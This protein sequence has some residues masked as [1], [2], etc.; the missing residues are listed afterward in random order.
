MSQKLFFGVDVGGTFTKV[1]LVNEHGRI[2]SKSKFSSSGFSNKTFFANTLKENLSLML[3]NL[4]LSFKQVK[5][6]GI[7]LPGPVDFD[8][9]IVLSLTNIRGWNKFPLK[10][11]LSKYFKFSVFIEN[12]ANCMALAEDRVGAAKGS[13]YAICLTLGT[14]VGGGIILD[15]Q[16]YRGPYYLGGEIGHV[17]ISSIGPKCQCGGSGCLEKYIGNKKLLNGARSIFNKPISLEE[18]SVLA[19]S[20]DRRAIEFW[21]N[22][23]SI[24]GRA[25]AGIVN[26]LGLETV[27]VGGGIAD[28]G[29]VLLDSV[30]DSVRLYSMKQIKS[31]IRIKKASLGNDAGD[32]GAALLAKEKL[33]Q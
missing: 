5:G 24:L 16:I 2:I 31:K 9:G 4:K 6:M 3:S 10:T 22:V 15:G 19:A 1:V 14:G 8:K 29:R 12:D 26:V 21:V 33:S 18:V 17:P 13:P 23:G 28:S 20:G 11:Y 32:L 7:G 27:V 25:V 30:R